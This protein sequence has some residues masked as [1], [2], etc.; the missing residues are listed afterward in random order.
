MDDVAILVVADDP[1]IRTTVSE[2]LDLE[3]Y[4]VETACDGAEALKVLEQA[5][6]SLVLLD[7]RMPV[8]D[9]WGF[10]RVVKERGL[11]LP[12]LV[13]TAAQNAKRWADE[14]GAAGYLAKPFELLDLLAA[15]ERVH[16]SHARDRGAHGKL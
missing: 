15:V 14:I 1:S 8:L 6:P 5:F 9:G 13:M 16:A 4:V 7:M 11:Q 2:I 3:G 12:I 10:A